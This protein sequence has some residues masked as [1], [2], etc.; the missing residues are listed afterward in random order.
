[1]MLPLNLLSVNGLKQL[2][3]KLLPWL[4]LIV[5]TVL[6]YLFAQHKWNEALETK[7]NA[8]V[9]DGKQAVVDEYENKAAQL[10][11]N[12]EIEKGLV[13]YDAQKRIATAKRDADSSRKSAL[14]LQQTLDRIS[15]DI[16]SNTNIDPTGKTA[17]ETVRVLTDLFKESV[18]RGDVLAEYADESR[19]AGLTCERSYDSLRAKYESGQVK[20]NAKL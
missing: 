19:E 1:M 9:K 17:R 16:G 13:E 18:R 7:Y 6:L 15:S 4:V 3:V 11:N 12:L 14:S 5:V 10:R 20:N 2:A 8:G